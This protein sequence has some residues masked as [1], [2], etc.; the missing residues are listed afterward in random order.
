MKSN[1]SINLVI[2]VQFARDRI[3]RPGRDIFS[4]R[5]GE[6]LSSVMISL[7]YAPKDRPNHEFKIVSQGYRMEQSVCFRK[8]QGEM[9]CT[10]CH[11]PHRA[12]QV[13]NKA[14]WFRSRC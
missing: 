13:P 12:V 1:P 6:R 9:T 10:T 7:D 11:D 4:Y 14:R 3:V 5:P 8:S 2:R